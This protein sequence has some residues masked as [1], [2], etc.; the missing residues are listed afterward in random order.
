MELS[1]K[2]RK[3]LGKK[4]KSLRRGGVLP[5]VVF[6]GG[7]PS[8]PIELDETE[9]SRVYNEA[10]ESTVIDLI[11]GKDKQDVLISEVQIDPLG[12][13]IHTDLK[14]V[15]AGEK[16]TAN[17][18]IEIVGEAAPV[19]TGE[20]ILLPLLDE[21]EVEAYPKDLPSEIKVDVS[22]LTEIGQGIEIKDLPIDPRKVEILGHES[23]ELVVKI[24]YP[25]VEEEEEEEEAPVS[26]EAAVAA[27]EATEE[28]PE[29]EGEEETSTEK[30][31]QESEE[32]KQD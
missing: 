4:V 11:L 13:V 14:R 20:G 10:G 7:K 22:N 12:K 29:G 30:E 8:L 9:F 15:A 17:V 24:D 26:E 3:I 18:A 23:N 31:P 25:Q 6:G 1:A 27:V 21:I 32:E 19:K 5:A 2:K 28:R 16:I